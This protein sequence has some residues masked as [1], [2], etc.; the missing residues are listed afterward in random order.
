[1]S[2]RTNSNEEIEEASSEISKIPK[3]SIYHERQSKQLC[4]L[5]ALNNLFQDPK[6]FRKEDLD[7]ICN[8]LAPGYK[9]FNPHRSTLGL[10]CYDVNVI[11][12]AL[13]KK[14][15][16]VVWFD[17]RKDLSSLNLDNIFGFILNVPNVPSTN[18]FSLPL[19]Y[20]P[21]RA[22]VWSSEKHWISLRKIGPNYYNLDSKLA[23]PI[24]IG[25]EAKLVNYLKQESFQEQAE[26]LIVIPKCISEDQSWLRK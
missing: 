13:A 3:Q 11:I 10:G 23:F 12:T 15:L 9:L 6:A 22:Q 24:C 2:N 21:R 17:K 8:E 19:S 14:N 7:A 5:H 18:F 26:L 20:I 25:D 1:M 16:E 4:A